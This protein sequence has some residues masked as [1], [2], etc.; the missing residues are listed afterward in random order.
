MHLHVVQREEAARSHALQIALHRSALPGDP[1][2]MHKFQ[3]VVRDGQGDEAQL[4][5]R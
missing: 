3:P 4:L 5:E 1:E 2:G